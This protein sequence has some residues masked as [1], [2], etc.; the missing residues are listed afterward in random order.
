MIDMA[1][2]LMLLL[3]AC[4]EDGST[5]MGLGDVPVTPP[6]RARILVHVEDG[7]AAPDRPMP[8]PVR[9]VVT[10][11]DGSHPDGSGRGVYADGRFFAEAGFSVEVPPGRTAIVLRSGPDY[12]PLVIEVEAKEGREVRYRARL[13]RWFAPEERGWFGGDNHVHAQH[14]ATAAIP[15]DLAF[16][17][18]QARADGLSYVTE[19]DPGPSPA[20]VERLST[21]AFLFRR[22][23][24][25]RPGPFVGH[26]NTPGIPRPIEPEV[27]ARLVDG[28]LPAQ[29]IAE[30]VHARGGAVIHTHP[31]TPPHQM[32]WMG[33]AEILSDAVLGRCADA[34]DLDG[35]ASEMLW[36]AV[37]NL[38]NRVAAS[39]YTDC[40]LGRRTTPSPGDR[41]V[42][43]QAERLTY[44]AI[45]EAIRRGHTFATNGGPL[46]PFVTIDGKGPGETLGPG[47]GRPHAL[48]AEV[49]CLY[50]LKSARLYRRG[51]LA[52]SFAVS[53]RRGEVVLEGTLR[54]PPGDRAWYV[55]RLEDERGHWAITSPIYVEPAQA[56]ARPF[57]SS[58][59][60]EIS[61]AT[62]YIELRRCF[63]AHLIVTVSPGD[64]LRSV[65]LLRDG[66][67]VRL[68][69]PGMGESRT[70]GKVPATGM[71]GEYGPG[72][73]WSSGA[74]HFQADWPV[75]ET[76]W[77]GLRAATA[78]GKTLAADEVFFDA[79]RGSSQVLTVARLDG[80]GTRWAHRGYGEELPLSE[81]R[82][83]FNGDHWW[84]P[85]RS[86]WR[87][88]AEFGPERCELVGGEKEGSEGLFRA[89][90]R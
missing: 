16:T 4:L 14:D 68:F 67:L 65:E 74:S 89:P 76:G 60:L 61:N 41:R 52:E 23:P 25:V 75:E 43:C 79:S 19:A 87:V 42:Y 64:R 51:E 62:R 56:S 8:L 33:A 32:H 21:P 90:P 26:L 28:P 2:H 50:P 49:R 88:L 57:A 63:F 1:A 7:R 59:I 34:L 46:F 30:E 71:A 24:E 31:L 55:L 44:P 15:T 17:A 36:F 39:S 85:N 80:P 83:P 66:R 73:S 84:Y 48:R 77:Y 18:L 3:V 5:F 11:S 20:G 53:G 69:A 40:A 29:G 37:L 58:L 86:Y 72:W 13:R 47:G 82:K 78:D 27:Y 10:A 45:V 9:V 22:A 81:I 12:V 38:G 54:D 70:A 35:Q 6:V